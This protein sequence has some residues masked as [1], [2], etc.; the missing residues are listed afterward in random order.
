MVTEATHEASKP[1]TICDVAEVGLQFGAKRSVWGILTVGAL[2]STMWTVAFLVLNHQQEKGASLVN[3]SGKLRYLSLDLGFS[4]VN[5]LDG[6]PSTRVDTVEQVLQQLEVV[7][8]SLHRDMPNSAARGMLLSWEEH[9]LTTLRDLVLSAGS[10]TSSDAPRIIQEAYTAKGQADLTVS[11]L[12]K[13]VLSRN[14]IVLVCTVLR[15]VV[16][17][18]WALVSFVILARVA[19]PF[20]MLSARLAD[21]QQLVREMHGGAQKPNAERPEWKDRA[22]LLQSRS[23]RLAVALYGLSQWGSLSADCSCKESDETI[24]PVKGYMCERV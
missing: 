11:A 15:A 19:R 8:A 3:D 22:E 5:G 21:A 23:V 6:H 10:M 1:F 24:S 17:L 13:E 7:T 16:G 4:L 14:H 9:H 18:A 2:L 12:E 20:P